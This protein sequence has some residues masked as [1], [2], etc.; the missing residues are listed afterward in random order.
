ME[1]TND[2]EQKSPILEVTEDAKA[3]LKTTATWTSFFAIL[4]F[5]YVGLMALSGIVVMLGGRFLPSSM[6]GAGVAIGIV[7]IIMAIILLIPTLYLY[8][9]SQRTKQALINN[10]KIILEEAF[11]N[12]KS[13]WKFIGIMTIIIIAIV[14]FSYL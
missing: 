4:S 10:D 13:Y 7:Y 9:S 6:G 11:Q 5:I 14:I 12:M 3:Y 2:L 1:H 8:R